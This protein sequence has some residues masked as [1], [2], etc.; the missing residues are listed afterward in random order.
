VGRRAARRHHKLVCLR[1][2]LAVASALTS[3]VTTAV[4][5]ALS[6]TGASAVTTAAVAASALATAGQQNEFWRQTERFVNPRRRVRASAH[7]TRSHAP[8]PASPRSRATNRARLRSWDWSSFPVTAADTPVDSKG[9]DANAQG[10]HYPDNDP[11]FKDL[12]PS[13]RKHLVEE[14]LVLNRHYAA[15][16]CTPSR[17]QLLSG[18]SVATQGNGEWEPVRPRYTILPEKLK[19]AGYKTHVRPPFPTRARVAPFSNHRLQPLCAQMVG[20]YHLGF[21]D[22]ALWPKKRGFDTSAGFHFSGMYEGASGGPDLGSS[23]QGYVDWSGG[24]GN[25]RNGFCT[26]ELASQCPT[27]PNQ[28]WNANDPSENPW[29]SWTGGTYPKFTATHGNLD[30]RA[31]ATQNYYDIIV[32]DT[33]PPLNV[34]CDETT[35]NQ[36][37]GVDF[38]NKGKTYTEDPTLVSTWQDIWNQFNLHAAGDATAT[39]KIDALDAAFEATR[40]VVKTVHDETVAA[41]RNHPVDESFFIYSSTPAMRFEGIANKQ[42][43]TRTYAA[44]KDKINACDHMDPT[45]PHH[46]A[47]DTTTGM[48]AMK[49]LMGDSA[50]QTAFDTYVRHIACSETKKMTRFKT[51]AFASTVDDL[52][53]ASIAAL[54][55]RGIWDKTLVIFSSDNGAWAGGQVNPRSHSTNAPYAHITLFC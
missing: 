24:N 18:R 30:N 9:Y 4:T 49:T 22:G 43:L 48:H 19:A 23:S 52:L 34:P 42:Q 11:L 37:E 5:A 6:T 10:G 45:A 27:A 47:Q 15:S 51:Y 32:N 21:Q 50:F 2:A 17:K 35:I 33:H 16:V 13:M 26:A 55:E 38:I 39:A 8:V 41:I 44:M 28:Y 14:G 1:C 40:S 25:I 36:W 20:K 7:R 3:A 46:S 31:C 53:N 29:G 12:F 54:Y